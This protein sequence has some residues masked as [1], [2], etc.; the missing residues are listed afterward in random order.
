MLARSARKAL[1]SLVAGVPVGWLL[2]IVFIAVIKHE[3]K[4]RG[5]EELFQLTIP[6]HRPVKEV[7]IRADGEAM[8]DCYL[9]FAFRV[10]LSLA[11][12]SAQNCQSRGGI[13]QSELSPPKSIK[14]NQDRL[15]HKPI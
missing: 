2:V 8:Q 5:K 10:L 4:Q 15:T 9:P 7:R 13:A 12:C 3:Q 6:H 14:K 11:S 1:F